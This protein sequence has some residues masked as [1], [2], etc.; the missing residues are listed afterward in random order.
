MSRKKYRHS[1]AVHSAEGTLLLLGLPA[2][3]AEDEAL[4]ADRSGQHTDS[5]GRVP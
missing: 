4:P 1:V 3:W 5:L 2:V